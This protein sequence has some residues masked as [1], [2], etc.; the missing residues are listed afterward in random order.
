MGASQLLPTASDC[1]LVASMT[2]NQLHRFF[3]SNLTI[4]AKDEIRKLAFHMWQDL[5]T[6][7]PFM[8]TEDAKGELINV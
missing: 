2:L 6:K 4:F 1:I 7:M 3:R 5:A 8:W